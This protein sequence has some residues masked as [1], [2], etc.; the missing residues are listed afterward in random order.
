MGVDD[1]MMR[2]EERMGDQVARESEAEQIAGLE[3]STWRHHLA[4]AAHGSVR[5]RSHLQLGASS[6][7]GF[8]RRP[9]RNFR[10]QRSERP[11]STFGLSS[12]S[13]RTG[14]RFG[15]HRSSSPSRRRS[16]R[17]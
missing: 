2:K 7:Q 8:A 4:A 16:Y 6:D 1:R 12:S 10:D 11:R 9:S 3:K 14:D 13:S 5:V 15:D 17:D